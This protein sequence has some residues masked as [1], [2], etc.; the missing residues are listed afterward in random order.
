MNIISEQNINKIPQIPFSI[1][2]KSCVKGVKSRRN[3]AKEEDVRLQYLVQM[4][5]TKDW[6]LISYYMLLRN[7]RQCK[8]RFKNYLSPKINLKPWTKEEDKMLIQKVT[9]FGPKWVYISKF[10]EGRSDNNLKN[11]W[12][13][14]LNKKSEGNDNRSINCEVDENQIDYCNDFELMLSLDIDQ[15]FADT[16]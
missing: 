13:T 11:R 1:Y 9:E 8:D 7:A 2:I 14:H 6:K 16:V 12:Y 5:G 3:F 10:F 4:F 15:I